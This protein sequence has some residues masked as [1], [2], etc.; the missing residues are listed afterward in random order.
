MHS[1]FQLLKT[2]R[3]L[4]SIVCLDADLFFSEGQKNSYSYFFRRHVTCFLSSDKK[5]AEI[6][7]FGTSQQLLIGQLVIDYDF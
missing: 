3:T 7:I 1:Y 6:V 2:P 5:L 4:E